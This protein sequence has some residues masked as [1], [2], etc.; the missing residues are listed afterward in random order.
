MKRKISYEC[1]FCGKLFFSEEECRL[2]E[3]DE[4]GATPEQ[5]R[6]FC[7]LRHETINAS[8]M[9]SMCHNDETRERF[10]KACESEVEFEKR[11]K[12]SFDTWKKV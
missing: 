10:D 1:S 7:R 12:I 11:T 5:F 4:I 2:H 8:S 6:E 3:L 9:M